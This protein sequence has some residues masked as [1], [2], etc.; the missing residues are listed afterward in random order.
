[1]TPAVRAALAALTMA[2]APHAAGTQGHIVTHA[3]DAAFDDVRLDLETAIINR[4][5]VTTKP[6]SA[7]CWCARRPMSAPSGRCSPGRSR[8]SSA[9]RSCRAG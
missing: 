9:R 8:S 6:S 2:V 7:R 5:L 3:V 1:M 4:G